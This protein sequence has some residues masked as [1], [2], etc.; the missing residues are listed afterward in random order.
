MS[1]KAYNGMMTRDDFTSLK[2]NIVSRIPRFKEKSLDALA[3][4]FANIITRYVDENQTVSDLIK[5]IPVGE[6]TLTNELNKLIEV[7]EKYGTT[8]ISLIQFMFFIS[9][10][11]S[12]GNI[13]NSFMC[14]MILNIE[15]I[16]NK[17]LVYPVTNVKGHMEILYEFLED[18]YVQDQS[19][20][21]ENVEEDEWK[22]RV[23]DWNNFNEMDGLR[24]KMLLFDSNDFCTSLNNKFPTFNRN[25]FMERI[26]E[27]IPSEKERVKKVARNKLLL[28]FK[29]KNEE[30][31]LATHLLF[32]S[33]EKEGKESVDRYINEH[34]L[35]LPKITK[36]TLKEKIRV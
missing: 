5:N 20:M 28:K 26:L 8:N 15:P 21:D 6:K 31:C 23:M 2:K 16:E 11:M 10:I 19:D 4:T 36:E 17:I 34:N 14:N 33:S 24:I 22:E 12:K 1:L 35:T 9:N 27:K 13:F 29:E 3:K 32:L 25:D 18:W 30:N 7:K